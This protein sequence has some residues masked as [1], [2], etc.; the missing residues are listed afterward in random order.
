LDGSKVGRPQILLC[1][2]LRDFGCFFLEHIGLLAEYKHIRST[3]KFDTLGGDAV[4][5]AAVGGIHFL[6]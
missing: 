5:H 1:R 4:I 2:A 6:F 3:V